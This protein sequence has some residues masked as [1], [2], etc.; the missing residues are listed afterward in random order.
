MKHPHGCNEI[1]DCY[2]FR[3]AENLSF[4]LDAISKAATQGSAD[5]CRVCKAIVKAS[6]EKRAEFSRAY[7]RL[8]RTKNDAT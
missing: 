5:G 1:N 3:L 2:Y 7:E 8:C 4:A 6:K